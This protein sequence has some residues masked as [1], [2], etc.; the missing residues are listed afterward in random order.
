MS[1]PLKSVLRAGRRVP[2]CYAATLSLAVSR[3]RLLLAY[4]FDMSRRSL[5]GS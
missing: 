5:C 3:A 4:L 1:M 2:R